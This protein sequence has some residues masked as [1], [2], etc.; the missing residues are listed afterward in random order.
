MAKFVCILRDEKKENLTEDLVIKHVE[1]LK[2][3]KRNGILILC[4]LILKEGGMLILDVKTQE[5]AKNI[6]L[7]DPLIKNNCYGDYIIYEFIEGNEE[8]NYLLN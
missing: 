3:L 6:I 1:H 2:D 4:G 5:E 7:Q 8:N